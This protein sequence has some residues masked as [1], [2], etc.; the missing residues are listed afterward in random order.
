MQSSDDSAGHT[1]ETERRYLGAVAYR[2]LGSVADAEGAVQDAWL[3][4]RSSDQ[5]DVADPRAYLTAVLTRIC[6]DLLGSARS[7][8]EAYYGEWLPEPQVTAE[9]TPEEAA[10]PGEPVSLATLTVLEQLSAAERTAF[11]LHDVFAVG[12]EEIASALERSPDAARQLA[13]R[14]RRRVRETAPPRPVDRAA[15]R[16][17]VQAFAA[18]TVRGDIPAL[19]TVLDPDVV[20]HS[21][22]GSAVRAGLQPVASARRVA[23]LIAGIAAK[24]GAPILARGLRAVEVNGSPGL[25][26]FDETGRA[27][28]V[29]AFTVADDRITEAFVMVNPEKLTRV[30]LSA[31]KDRV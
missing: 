20:W 5:A 8:H 29:L 15:Q 17:A 28:A 2:L 27:V 18:A 25:A 7:R 23:P 10:E 31:L 16:R 24:W 1:F 4:W 13:S 19:M 9:T 26:A 22:G 14:A 21:D 6:Y 30:N 11:V 3:R 12:F